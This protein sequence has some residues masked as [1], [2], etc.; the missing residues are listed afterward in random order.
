[1]A[2]RSPKGIL[3][4]VFLWLFIL[5]GMAA[6]VRYFVMPEYQDKQRDR[7]ADQTGSEGKYKIEARVAADS[8]SGYAVL[9][10]PALADRL[11]RE[12]IRFSVIDDGAD[13][14]KR[15]QALR[16]DEVDLAVFPVNSFIQCGARLGE[17]PASIIY[18]IDETK[19]ADAIVANRK[20]VPGISSLDS[21]DARIVLTPDSPSEFL[22]RVM[23]ASFS[24]PRLPEKDWLVKADGAE[25]VFKQYRVEAAGKLR[26][27]A[28]WEPYVSQALAEPGAHVLID[29]SKL[30]GYIVDVLVARRQFLV[31]DYETIRK[32][33]ECYARTAYENQNKLPD[34]I[35]ADAK[36]LGENIDNNSARQMAKGIEWKNTLENYAHF[37]L[38][39]NAALE[40]IE[41]IIIKITGVLLKTGAMESNPLQGKESSLY[42]DKLLRQMKDSDFHPGRE[43]NVISGMDV[44][45]SDEKIRGGEKLK[46]LNDSQW[47]S[48]LTVGELR[49]KPVAFGR[50]TARINVQSEHELAALA[51]TLNS[52]PQYYLTVTGKVRAGGDEAAALKLAKER[53]DAVVRFLRE[54]GVAAERIR[55]FSQIGESG[56]VGDQSVSFVVGQLPY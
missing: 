45:A 48:L 3:V 27:Y 41:D 26:A 43:I 22:A 13:Y 15:M 49:V 8:F 1:M 52:W 25:E 30:K 50:G 17:F 39:E 12:G 14:M 38:Q 53:A 33:L 34:L 5:G 11:G 28:L 19:G 10:T 31:D 2:G 16:D 44:G 4:A 21:P 23:L 46:A 42:F 18:I 36:S 55:S 35:T 6:A 9:R 24:L 37:G 51:G 54:K 29:S 7:L 40:N 32:V 20:M 56:G 47:N